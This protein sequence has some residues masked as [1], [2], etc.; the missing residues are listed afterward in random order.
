M[1]RRHFIGALAATLV[2]AARETTAQE[3]TG[4]RHIGWLGAN[5]IAI[6]RRAITAF[7]EALRERGWTEGANLVIDFKF[8][9]GRLERL[10]TLAAELVASNVDIIVAGSSAATRAAANASRTIPIVM[11][12]SADALG[13]R[14]VP[15]LAQPKGNITGMTFLAGS[16][17]AGKQFELLRQIVPSASTVA[18]LANPSNASHSGYVQEVTAASSRFGTKLQV[19]QADSVDKLD[20]AFVVIARDR[21]AALLVLTD[22]FFLGRR[23]PIVETAAKN[24]VAGM[25]SQREFVEAGGLICYGPSLAD[26]YRRAAG[27]VDKILR[28]AKPG[29]LPVEQPTKF[30][31]VLNLR[32][33]KALGL[34]IP[35]SILLGADD[36][37]E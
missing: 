16:S 4:V 37:I 5:N 34:A 20:R 28:G 19:L 3:P 24:A 32:V 33:A 13:E 26:M 2:A 14:L 12:A 27:H 6:A 17:I 18:V 7:R 23:H 15:S 35:Q 29:D 25:Y 30:E 1:N 9:D 8:A 10:P 31:L 21:P 11:A 36:I 22:A